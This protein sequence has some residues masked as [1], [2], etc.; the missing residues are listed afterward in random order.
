MSNSSIKINNHTSTIE[1]NDSK[2]FLTLG[3][4]GAIKIGS[5]D[6]LPESGSSNISEYKGVLRYN[7]ELNILEF[8]DGE[9]WQAILTDNGNESN[10]MIMWSLMF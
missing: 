7:D 4:K 2:V 5:G 6:N 3:D 9:Q 8:C 10:S 1:T